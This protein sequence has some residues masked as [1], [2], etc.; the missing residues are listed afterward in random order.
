MKIRTDFVTNSSSSSFVIATDKE[1]PYLYK[2]EIH[3]I[4]TDADIL[5]AIARTSDYEY[6][7]ISYDIPDEEIQKLGNFTDEQMILIKLA[8]CG[9]IDRYKNISEELKKSEVPLYH[10]FVDRDW[11][12]AQ[13]VLDRFIHDAKIVDEKGDL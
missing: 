1:I 3:K 9:E 5:Q 2:D 4:A 10:I 13:T 8:V 6:I 12:Y 11:L 7:S